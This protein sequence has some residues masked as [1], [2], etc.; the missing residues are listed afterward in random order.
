MKTTALKLLRIAMTVWVISI[1]SFVISI[2][3]PGDPISNNPKYRND[4][5]QQSTDDAE[6]RR[7]RS[8]LGLDLPYFYVSLQPSVF[9]DTIMRIPSASE[10]KSVQF[11][12]VTNGNWSALQALR[13]A[14]KEVLSEADATAAGPLINLLSSTSSELAKQQ[15]ETLKSWDNESLQ[16]IASQW[17]EYMDRQPESGRNIPQLKWNGL[18]NQYHHWL[19][20][21]LS[22]NL[23]YS[24]TDGLPISSK[25][26]QKLGVSLQL[27]LWSILLSFLIAIPTGLYAGTHIGGW[28]DRWTYR[29]A[30]TWYA[31]PSFFVGTLLL[32]LFSNPDTLDILPVGGLYDPF[33]YNEN[34][35]FFRKAIHRI[36]YLVL[37]VFTYAYGLTAVL[38]RLFRDS[39]KT[40]SEKLHIT[41]ARAKGLSERRIRYVHI[42]KNAAFPLITVLGRLLPVAL[43][44]S[45]IVETIFS[46]PGMGLGLYDAMLER[47]YP[48]IV[49]V[50]TLTGVLTILGYG[51]S[52]FL[53]TIFDPRVKNK[54]VEK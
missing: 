40:E 21:F 51:L 38:I 46:I 23:G 32:L 13:T 52:D 49:A 44:G 36:P 10:R 50:F 48:F 9:P 4:R 31:L 37:P 19:T 17:T 28:F 53:Y 41:A 25:I 12:L 47:D 42:F 1:I 7:L 30:M 2:S 14:T 5:P 11:W 45:V 35:S 33:D 8:Q 3:A 27:I 22:G 6:V 26:S 54:S 29:I 24:Y 18:S 43:G 20:S 39:V 15:V 16:Q 34:W